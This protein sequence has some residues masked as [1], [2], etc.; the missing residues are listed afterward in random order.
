MFNPAE[1]LHIPHSCLGGLEL[2]RPDCIF[3]YTDHQQLPNIGKQIP[4][5]LKVRYRI[6][7]ATSLSPELEY[8]VNS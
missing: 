8:D 4:A 5:N 7:R 3:Q 2:P 1:S 6:R